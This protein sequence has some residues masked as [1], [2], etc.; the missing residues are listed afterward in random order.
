MWVVQIDD[1]VDGRVWVAPMAAT[2]PDT[3]EPIMM[4]YLRLWA[5]AHERDLDMLFVHLALGSTP[6]Q[7]PTIIVAE[8]DPGDNAVEFLLE[9]TAHEINSYVRGSETFTSQLAVAER[10]LSSEYPAN[11][12]LH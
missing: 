7:P 3:L 9:L 4:E 8:C 12:T 11:V 2:G 10:M 6:S 5:I 1:Q